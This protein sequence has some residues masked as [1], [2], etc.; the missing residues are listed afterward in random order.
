M[1]VF[2]PIID[3]GNINFIYKGCNDKNVASGFELETWSET[4]MQKKNP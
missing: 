4:E 1:S 2:V 3:S